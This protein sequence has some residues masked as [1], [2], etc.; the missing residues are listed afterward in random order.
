MANVSLAI[1]SLSALLVFRVVLMG[2]PNEVVTYIPVVV[3]RISGSSVLP[4]GHI[5]YLLL[6]IS[7]VDISAVTLDN[8]FHRLLHLGRFP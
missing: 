2:Q 1:V 5:S 7:S 8:L 3:G 6:K 4:N